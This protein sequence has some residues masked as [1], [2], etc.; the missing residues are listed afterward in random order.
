M[1]KKTLVERLQNMAKI[2]LDTDFV[3]TLNE[4]VEVLTARSTTITITLSPDRIHDVINQAFI[5][6]TG[7]DFDY[8]VQAVREK[9]ERED[10]Y[11]QEE[12]TENAEL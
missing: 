11:V 10:E 6:C 7:R 3:D 12:T 8:V 9:M 5:N 2:M 4:A 1:D